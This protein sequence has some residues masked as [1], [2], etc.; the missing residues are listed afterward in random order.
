MTIYCGGQCE[1]GHACCHGGLHHVWV[2]WLKMNSDDFREHDAVCE[3]A[4]AI[5]DRDRF[6]RVLRH[7][8]Q[9]CTQEPDIAQLAARALDG[10]ADVE[11]DES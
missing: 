1:E 3:A 9:H 2:T 10:S 5:Q 11:E 8:A 6:R 7:I 4:Y